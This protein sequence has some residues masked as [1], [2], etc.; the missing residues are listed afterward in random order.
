MA[1]CSTSFLSVKLL[2][3]EVISFRASATAARSSVVS[4][5]SSAFTWA[6]SS[7]TRSAVNPCCWATFRHSA[8]SSSRS[9][10]ALRLPRAQGRRVSLLRRGLLLAQLPLNLLPGFENS[11]PRLGGTPLSEN[12]KPSRSSRSQGDSVSPRVRANSALA[13]SVLVDFRGVKRPVLPVRPAGE[14]EGDGVDVELRVELAGEMPCRNRAAASPSPLTTSAPPRPSRVMQASSSTYL[15]LP[16]PLRTS[17]LQ[18]LAWS[19][20]RQTHGRSKRP[21]VLRRSGRMPV[22]RLLAVA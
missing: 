10:S 20:G 16:S 15:V 14:I 2:W 6:L 19:P 12:E 3:L 13:V 18:S 11:S 4:S 9:T 17:P 21:S 22:A 5:R 1:V 7:L 8:R